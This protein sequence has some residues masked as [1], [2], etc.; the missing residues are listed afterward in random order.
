MAAKQLKETDNSPVAGERRRTVTVALKPKPMYPLLNRRD[1]L[2]TAAS[3]PA[4]HH[5]SVN[6]IHETVT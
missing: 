4:V 3:S 6:E 1:A 5:P 2:K